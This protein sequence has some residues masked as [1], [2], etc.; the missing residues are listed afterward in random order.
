M[1]S[2]KLGL[3]IIGGI[4]GCISVSLGD[5]LLANMIW[6][7]TNPFMVWHN[8]SVNEKGQASLWIIYVLIA[9]FGVIYNL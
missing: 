2:W 5:S 9:T 3:G 7:V 6:M 8:I 4:S 1:K